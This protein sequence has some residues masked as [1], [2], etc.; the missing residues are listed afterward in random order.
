MDI[1]YTCVIFAFYWKG[2]PTTDKPALLERWEEQF[3]TI[4]NRL[5][6]FSGEEKLPIPDTDCLARILKEPLCR[7]QSAKLQ[8]LVLFQLRFTS[9]QVQSWC[10][11]LQ[12]YS[13]QCGQRKRN[14]RTLG[15]HPLFTS[16][17]RNKSCMIETTTEMSQLPFIRKVLLGL[18]LII[19]T[20]YLA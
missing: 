15:M 3:K 20:R 8:D 7:C 4:V 10:D 18:L 5:S 13:T 2:K 6:L 9:V 12:I 11:G 19:L 14:Y 16:T 17:N 1:A